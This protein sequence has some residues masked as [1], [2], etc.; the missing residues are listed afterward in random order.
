MRPQ[1][2]FRTPSTVI[3]TSPTA[4]GH[5]GVAVAG[6]DLAAVSMAHDAGPAAAARLGRVLGESLDAA[7]LGRSVDA[8]DKL[9]L[10][11]L[12]RLVRLLSGEPVGLSDLPLSL[13][14]LSPFQQRVVA[15]CRAIP[16]GVTRSYGQVAAAAGSPGAA[17]AV[18]QVMA[19]NRTPLVVPCHRVLAAGGKIGGF[20]APS[21]LALKRKLLALEA[22]EYAEGKRPPR[23]GRSVHQSIA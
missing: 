15:A 6:G 3:F 14:H 5:L 12:D 16:Y 23:G 13:G 19:G 10:D 22:G 21:G 17:R 11:V 8:D 2:V 4:I 7:T 20:S 18:G 9:A 1:Y